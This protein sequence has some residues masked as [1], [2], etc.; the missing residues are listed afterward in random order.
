M[1]MF[2]IIMALSILSSAG[3]AQSDTCYP[4]LDCPQDV[5]TPHKPGRDNPPPE[6]PPFDNTTVRPPYSPPHN[7]ARAQEQCSNPYEAFANALFGQPPNCTQPAT[8]C[9]LEDGSAVPLIA[10]GLFGAQ[11]FAQ[12]NFFGFPV[13]QNGLACRR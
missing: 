11:C 7:P 9:C 1:G 10:P 12:R 8:H 4:G 6:P 5:P 2:L 3:W 13:P